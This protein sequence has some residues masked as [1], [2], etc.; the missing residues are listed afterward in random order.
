MAHLV[1]PAP[2]EIGRA[3]E[4]DIRIRWADGHESVYPSVGLRLAC[5][6]AACAQQTRPQPRGQFRLMP[7]AIQA[8]RPE[9]IE[10]V[11]SFGLRVFWSDGH[12]QGLYG[13]ERLRAECPC[14]QSSPRVKKS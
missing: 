4:H 12:S 3:N 2:I 6:C 13:F 1:T 7:A 8:V 9:R 10:I 11:G 5:P 14:C